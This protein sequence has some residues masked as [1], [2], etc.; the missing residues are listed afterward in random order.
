MAVS[1]L[2]QVN[3]PLTCRPCEVRLVPFIC[4]ESYQVLPVGEFCTAM[5]LNCG[6]G[7]RAF[8]SVLLVE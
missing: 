3:V 7:R 8:N 6:N 5:V 4:S 1:A 2:D